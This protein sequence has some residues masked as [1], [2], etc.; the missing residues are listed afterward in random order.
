MRFETKHCGFAGVESAGG[1]DMLEPM[2][3]R[4]EKEK[5]TPFSKISNGLHFQTQKC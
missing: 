2:I 4:T 3:D 5:F 1:C